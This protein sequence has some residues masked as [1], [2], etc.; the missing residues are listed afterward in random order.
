MKV[1]KYFK[2]LDTEL[3]NI[4]N[5]YK[6]TNGFATACLLGC[7][8]IASRS[9]SEVSS[10]FKDQ[11]VLKELLESGQNDSDI[12][13][14]LILDNVEFFPKLYAYYEREYL[15]MEYVDGES[16]HDIFQSLS[17]EELDN[18]RK[19]YITATRYTMDKKLYDNDFKLEHIIWNR[20]TKKIKL[21]DLGLYDPVNKFFPS[22][23]ACLKGAID[24]F[25][26]KTKYHSKKAETF[27]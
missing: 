1:T 9:R 16:L 15:I 4:L 13:A 27:T 17:F 25:D 19:Q 22:Y 21:I 2:E 11:Y 6:P 12:N 3:Q 7:N 24:N 10:V 20:E 26:R 14:L 18:I 8:P 5:E 23:E